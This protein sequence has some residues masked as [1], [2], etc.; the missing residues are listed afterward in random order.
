MPGDMGPWNQ[1]RNQSLPGT[2]SLYARRWG[3]FS[4]RLRRA[5][6]GNRITRTPFWTSSGST[7]IVGSEGSLK[8]GTV[9]AS[10]VRTVTSK[11]CSATNRSH[12]SR[13][14]NSTPPT[15]GG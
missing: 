11:P 1:V 8:L 10:V 13:I 3:C 9:Y 7:G 4:S 5:R 14:E 12:M 6:V 15:A 2:R